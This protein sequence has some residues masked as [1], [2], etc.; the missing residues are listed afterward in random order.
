M[1]QPRAVSKSWAS[2]AKAS[3]ALGMTKGARVMLSTPPAM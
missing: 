1:R 3:L 2:R